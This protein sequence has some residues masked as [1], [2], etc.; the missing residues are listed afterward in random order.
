MLTAGSM[1]H[2]GLDGVCCIQGYVEKKYDGITS[3]YLELRPHFRPGDSIYL[4]EDNEALLSRL[5]PLISQADIRDI[6]AQPLGT[7]C[8]WTE[9]EPLRRE[10]FK[11]ALWSGDP[12]QLL[13]LINTIYARKKELALCGKKLRSSD[14]AFLKDAERLLHEEF[15]YVLGISP[16]EVPAYIDTTAS[17]AF[18]PSTAAEVIPPA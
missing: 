15:A 3:R 11:A 1:V 9:P 17:A 12:K 18:I 10:S 6:M 4:P 16:R 8:P 13:G 5:R 2:Y 14:A 7:P